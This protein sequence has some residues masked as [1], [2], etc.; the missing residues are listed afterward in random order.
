MEGQK[1]GLRAALAASRH[2][3]VRSAGCGIPLEGREGPYTTPQRERLLQQLRNQS[4]S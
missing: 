3:G 2:E 4:E 1:A